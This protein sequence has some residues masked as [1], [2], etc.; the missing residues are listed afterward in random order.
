M[1]DQGVQEI[2]RDLGIV[3]LDEERAVKLLV[4]RLDRSCSLGRLGWGRTGNRSKLEPER[5]SRPKP[6][7]D[8]STWTRWLTGNGRSQSHANRRAVVLKAD[9][10]RVA[11]SPALVAAS[12]SMSKLAIGTVSR[13]GHPGVEGRQHPDEGVDENDDQT[14]DDQFHSRAKLSYCL[15]LVSSCLAGKPGRSLS[16][17][18]SICSYRVYRKMSRKPTPFRGGMKAVSMLIPINML[19]DDADIWYDAVGRRLMN[20]DV[21]PNRLA[22]EGSF[23]LNRSRQT[24]STQ[25]F[26]NLVLA[27]VGRRSPRKT[28]TTR[29]SK[30]SWRKPGSPGDTRQVARGRVTNKG[31]RSTRESHVL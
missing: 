11:H 17:F 8:P 19:V 3:G 4:T 13:A 27:V 15:Q 25:L 20:A 26:E 30:V 31:L 2:A 23:G 22:G 12:M 14:Q 16:A 10:G 28:S 18:A 29:K 9:R 24:R 21:V 7:D 5:D 6:R 1:A